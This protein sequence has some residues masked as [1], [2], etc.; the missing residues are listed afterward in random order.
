MHDV[1]PPQEWQKP[2]VNVPAFR[3]EAVLDDKITMPDKM[4]GMLNIDRNDWFLVGLD[5]DGT[6]HSQ[7]LRVYLVDRHLVDVQSDYFTHVK[8]KFGF[9]PVTEFLVH[10]V[11]PA[12]Y[13][14]AI[15]HGF[16]L[17]LRTRGVGQDDVRITRRGD[18]PEQ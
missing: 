3:G 17:Q 4:F 12:D 15:T 7:S 16:Q 6:E 9:I 5:W 13:I 10:D 14:R 8:K 1:N 18:I 2:S 11:D